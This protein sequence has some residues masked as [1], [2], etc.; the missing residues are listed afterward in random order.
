M[1]WLYDRLE[2]EEETIIRYKRAPILYFGN[3]VIF[4]GMFALAIDGKY[5]LAF[6]LCGCGFA[7]S[8]SWRKPNIE[9]KS[10][11]REGNVQ[12]KGSKWSFSNPLTITI[13]KNQPNKSS[14]PT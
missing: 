5:F 7:L 4:V 14:E 12:I 1:S 11:M 10:A 9:V 8:M 6:I 3:L 2:T 13:Q